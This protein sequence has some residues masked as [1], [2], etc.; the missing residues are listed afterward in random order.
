MK[1]VRNYFYN[2]SYQLFLLIVPLITVPYISRT[3]GP[4]GV[5]INSLT[6]A[7]TQYFIYFATLGLTTYGQREIAY[8][9]DDKNKLTKTFWE[10]ELLSVFTT[11][12]AMLFFAV[13]IGIQAKYQKLYCI[14][15]L[16]VVSCA[17]DVSWVIMGTENFKVTVLRNFF[18]KI[19]SIILIFVFVRTSADLWKYVLI[20]SLS[21]LLG[22]IS[23]WPY[24]LKVINHAFPR[25]INIFKHLKPTFAL[26]IPQIAITVY[27]Y[28]NKIMLGNMSSV[29]QVGFFDSSDKL[30]RI[31]LTVVTAIST[32]M[33]P[34]AAKYFSDGNVN[35]LND[36]IKT[37]LNFA[38]ML[39]LPMAAGL[40]IISPRL[41]PIFFGLKFAPTS[42]VMIVEAISIIPI[43][44]SQII[45]VQYLISTKKTRIYTVS[46]VCGAVINLIANWFLIPSL[47]A[48]GTA[49]ATVIA[50]FLI[51]GMELAFLSTKI[52]LFWI[53]QDLPKLLLATLG[54]SFVCYFESMIGIEGIVGVL[55]PTLAGILSYFGLLLLLRVDFFVNAVGTI[56]D[57]FSH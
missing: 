48:V 51:A 41:V 30:V 31:A 23:L 17:L 57:K 5:G 18:V 15:A 38:L 55:L 43:S 22:N 6:L 29:L 9:R 2:L 10:I 47:G 24:L 21:T 40:M 7:S 32:V 14:E 4:S 16:L 28:F 45:G 39:A 53:F 1:N 36:S 54:M 35:K 19:T 25:K 50:E 20:T 34:S 27:V 13:F 46:I 56:S 8:V 44:I 52:S 42:Q 11:L 37:S 3:I 49:W 33:L 12:F 26:F